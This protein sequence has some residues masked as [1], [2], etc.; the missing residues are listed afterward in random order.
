MQMIGRIHGKDF[1]TPINNLMQQGHPDKPILLDVK[2]LET[3]Q[4]KEDPKNRH[5]KK[6]PYYMK[7]VENIDHAQGKCVMAEIEQ[8]SASCSVPLHKGTKHALIKCP[9]TKNHELGQDQFL[10]SQ[11]DNMIPRFI[12]N[13]CRT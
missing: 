12:P 3:D 7:S 6:K 4:R 11:N 1:C 10:K 9:F 8:E 5:T 13:V 2:F